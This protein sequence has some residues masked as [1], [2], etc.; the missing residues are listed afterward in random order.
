MG[1]NKKRKFSIAEWEKAKEEERKSPI[2][3]RKRK[4]EKHQR[5][6]NFETEKVGKPRKKKR[7]FLPKAQINPTPYPSPSSSQN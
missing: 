5:K 7:S 3:D 4:E 6:Q 2:K 1:E